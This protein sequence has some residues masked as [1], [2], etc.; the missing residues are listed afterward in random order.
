M[1]GL[2]GNGSLVEQ[3]I[4]EMVANGPMYIG[5]ALLIIEVRASR[6]DWR[7]RHD[8]LLDY[9]LEHTDL[10]PQDIHKAMNGK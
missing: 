8:R 1:V 3:L 10:T 6:D 5:L 9:V 4:V 2:V 7:V